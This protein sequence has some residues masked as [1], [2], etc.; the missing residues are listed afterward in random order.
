MQVPPIDFDADYPMIRPPPSVVE[1]LDNEKVLHWMKDIQ[2]PTIDE[3]CASI[4][5]GKTTKEDMLDRIY[6]NAEKYTE[7]EQKKENKISTSKDHYL[8]ESVV[9]YSSDRHYSVNSSATTDNDF[10]A[11]FG[12]YYCEDNSTKNKHDVTLENVDYDQT[13]SIGSYVD[14]K[15]VSM[16]SKSHQNHTATVSPD[17]TDE[18]IFEVTKQL[19]YNDDM[20][21][22]PASE[23]AGVY[24]TSDLSDSPVPHPLGGYTSCSIVMPSG[25][26]NISYIPTVTTPTS[27]HS[28]QSIPFGDYI[29]HDVALQHKS[30]IV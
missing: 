30:S 16:S 3:E 5:S 17:Y 26:K 25:N 18:S 12:D 21:Y 13:F 19:E 11:V 14:S 6:G 23:D 10:Q 1:S 28:N 8:S 24:S 29:D 22:V 4:C 7:D 27:H 9:F 15:T 20:P 2:M